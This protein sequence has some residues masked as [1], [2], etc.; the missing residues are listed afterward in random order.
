MTASSASTSAVLEA[1][2]ADTP[3]VL[4]ELSAAHRAA[5]DAVDPRTYELCRVRVAALLGTPGEASSDV[6]SPETLDALSSWPT[7]PHFT[8]TDRACLAFAEQFVIDVATLPDAMAVAVSD[9][10]GP[11][12]FA[13][14]VHAL[15]VIE[16]R[17]RLRLIWE[18]LLEE[19]VS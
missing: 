10:L 16:Q 15:L 7:S 3:D 9:R 1:T 19:P 12:G 14:F 11:E 2:L 17:Q 13:N 18:R 4:R 8:E 6:L 5:V